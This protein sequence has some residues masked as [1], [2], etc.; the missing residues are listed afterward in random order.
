LSATGKILS[1]WA[2]SGTHYKASFR[3]I[4]LLFAHDRSRCAAKGP[5]NK[6]AT[7]KASTFPLGIE[8]LIRCGGT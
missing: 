2:L 3:P 4:K 5:D 6:G 7:A 8:F 1:L